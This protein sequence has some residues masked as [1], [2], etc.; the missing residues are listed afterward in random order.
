MHEHKPK[1]EKNIKIRT[2]A[3]EQIITLLF[4]QLNAQYKKGFSNA[5]VENF[6]QFCLAETDEV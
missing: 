4:T 6:R 2:E 3:G 1:A 5:N